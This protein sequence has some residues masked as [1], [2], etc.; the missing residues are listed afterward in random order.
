[1]HGGGFGGRSSKPT[2]ADGEGECV[3]ASAGVCP[4]QRAPGELTEEALA[5]HLETLEVI[6]EGG[7]GDQR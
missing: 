5:A 1:M 3:G 4:H 2:G 6:C 7:G